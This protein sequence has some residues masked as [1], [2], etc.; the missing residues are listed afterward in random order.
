MIYILLVIR[1]ALR[2]ILVFLEDLCFVEVKAAFAELTVALLNVRVGGE[3]HQDSTLY[4]LV[5]FE[6]EATEISE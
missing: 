2:M 3:E 5:Q 4:A 1:H 6:E